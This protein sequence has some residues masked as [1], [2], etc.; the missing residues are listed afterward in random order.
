MRIQFANIHN[1]YSSL[2]TCLSGANVVLWPK[3]LTTRVA[4][5]CRV[6]V[7]WKYVCILVVFFLYINF[8]WFLFLSF[9]YIKL[10]QINESLQPFLSFC[11]TSVKNDTF[12][13]I[14]KF[15]E[16]FPL[17]SISTNVLLNYTNV[18]LMQK[19]FLSGSMKSSPEGRESD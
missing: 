1:L 16:S 17:T 9:F 7:D 8:L 10:L 11:W 15:N 12:Q 19:E 14:K 6:V 2:W 5:N 13:L 18:D 3:V 4:N